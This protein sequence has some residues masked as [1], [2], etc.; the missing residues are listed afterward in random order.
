M[1]KTFLIL[2]AMALVLGVGTS[3]A[4]AQGPGM[5][6]SGNL[7][8]V[9]VDDSDVTW[10]DGIRDEAE[11]D[12]GLGMTGA[13]G[14]NLGNGLRT[15][16]E[17][18]F[19]FN[20]VDRQFPEGIGGDVSSFSAMGNAFFDF[21]PGNQVS[22]FIGA[23]IGIANVEFDVDFWGEDDDTV[24]AYQFMAGVSYAVSYN[25]NIDLQYRYFATEDPNF[26]F[27]EAEYNTHS[28]MGGVR[29]NF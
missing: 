1:K 19:R 17:M 3:I 5:Y 6:F 28:M 11:F 14:Y 4:C 7:G 22:P 16:F 8:A 13:I 20:D 15:E 29:I 23:G 2:L 10:F 27:F 12:T 25:M 18:G 9:W 21:M 26:D 24:F